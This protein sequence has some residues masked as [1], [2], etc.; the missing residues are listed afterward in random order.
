[1][2]WPTDT[3][4]K[5][6]MDQDS[7]SPLLMRGELVALLDVV[8]LM[9]AEVTAA[10]TVYHSGNS[11]AGNGQNADLLDGQHGSFYQSASNINAGTLA[12]ARLATGFKSALDADL[13]DGQHGSYYRNAA[14][15][16]AGTILTARLPTTAVNKGGT[17]ST[18]SS[19]ART[20]L[21]LGALA[22]LSSVT[23]SQIDAGAVGSSEIA[24]NAVDSAEIVDGAATQAKI[25]TDAIIA[26]KIASQQVGTSELGQSSVTQSKINT[27]SGIV[28]TTGTTN[29]T[30]PGGQYG[31]YPQIRSS[32]TGG[33]NDYEVRL[34]FG[35]PVVLGTSYKA[36]IYLV[37]TEGNTLSAQQRYINSSPPYNLGDGGVPI[38]VFAKVDAME[39]QFQSIALMFHRGHTMGQRELQ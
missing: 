10:A 9:L 16:N 37:E 23:A 27:S 6:H 30:L 31:F 25:A 35:T 3:L 14:N 33:I 5:V 18:T 17:G 12:L 15:L 19:G 26:I 2:T 21:G 36:N 39:N 20:N 24:S 38:F 22:T 11:G 34:F 28:S 32:G 7:D 8:K 1:M 29:A 4:T 13:L